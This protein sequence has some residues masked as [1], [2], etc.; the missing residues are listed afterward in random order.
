MTNAETT[1]DPAVLIIRSGT[2]SHAV[3]PSRGAVTSPERR[4]DSTL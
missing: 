3:K 4:L 2:A 1:T